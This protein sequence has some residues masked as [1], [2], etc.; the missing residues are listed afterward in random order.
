[1][2]YLVRL[3]SQTHLPD[4]VINVG[5]LIVDTLDGV[6][7]PSQDVRLDEEPGKEIKES[8]VDKESEGCRL[9]RNLTV[10]STQFGSECIETCVESE[11]HLHNLK[12][13]Y[14][15]GNYSGNSVL[16]SPQ[17]VVGVH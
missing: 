5:H 2:T 10:D 14:D 13:S 4:V 6:A 12:A 9:H 15:H 1:M 3:G 16:K 8:D 11:D 17:S 7:L